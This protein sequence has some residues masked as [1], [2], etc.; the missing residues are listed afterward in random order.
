MLGL[1][2]A[3]GSVEELDGL[4]WCASLADLPDTL[5]KLKALSELNFYN[6]SNDITEPAPETPPT[7][8]PCFGAPIPSETPSSLCPEPRMRS[9]R[10]RN[11]RKGGGRPKGH[12][13]PVHGRSC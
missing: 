13:A 3:V 5:A 6:P 11:L 7:T 2:D 10:Q 12:R 4:A 8:I 1:P 9:S